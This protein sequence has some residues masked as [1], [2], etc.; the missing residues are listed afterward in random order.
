MWRVYSQH[1]AEAIHG[2]CFI[3][4]SRLSAQPQSRPIH[5]NATI[6]GKTI[7]AMKAMFGL[8]SKLSLSL[9]MGMTREGHQS[10]EESNQSWRVGGHNQRYLS[11]T[12]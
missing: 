2:N 8:F 11:S 3:A 7:A 12:S 5:S 9:G 4:D 6:F 10:L 1:D